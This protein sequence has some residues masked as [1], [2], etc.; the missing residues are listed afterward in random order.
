M[1]SS[2]YQEATTGY[3]TTAV[4]QA[5][6]DP[7]SKKD[8]GKACS[9]A[10][11]DDSGSENIMNLDIIEGKSKDNDGGSDDDSSDEGKSQTL[12]N[13]YNFNC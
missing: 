9:V 1:C 5:D 11:G 6:C 13:F 2:G 3:S 8:W 12:R 7:N 4:R 10:A